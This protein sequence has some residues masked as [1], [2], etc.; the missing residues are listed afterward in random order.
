MI[1]TIV[2]VVVIVVVIVVVRAS[3]PIIQFHLTGESGA[4]NYPLFRSKY[5]FQVSRCNAAA[6]I[7]SSHSCSTPLRYLT[8]VVVGV[9][10][11]NYTTTS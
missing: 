1:L 9:N 7:F 8:G 10:C 5:A 6:I 11:I 3:M 4:S 2:V